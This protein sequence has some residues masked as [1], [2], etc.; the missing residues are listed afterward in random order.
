MASQITYTPFGRSGTNVLPP[1]QYM[2]IGQYIVSPNGRYKLLL[3][4]DSNV[5]L[6]DGETAVWVADDSQPYSSNLFNRGF[7][8]TRF[9]VSNSIFL[10]DAQRSRL[11]TASTGRSEEG[12]WYRSHLSVQDDGNIVTLDINA[13][14]TTLNT[15]LLPNS[16]EVFI[17]PPGMSLE[18]DKRY[19]VGAYSL[20]FLND[21]NLAVFAQDGSVLWNAGVSGLG[22]AQAIMQSDGNFVIQAADGVTVWQTNT[23]GFSGAYAQI[24]SN[25][26]FVICLGTPLWARSG[27][28]PGKAPNVFYPV[29][30]EFNTY[31]HVIYSF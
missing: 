29:Q 18:V 8:E 6:F 22:G 23:A 17:F 27:W 21:G 31:N 7:V 10:E 14:F 1:N 24:Q 3:Q 25:G 15:T 13:L 30:G 9:Y 5:V 20:A 19:T 16:D 2:V 28:T 11:W 12:L 26:A 4:E